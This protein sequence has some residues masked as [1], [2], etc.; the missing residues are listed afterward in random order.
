[1]RIFIAIFV[2]ILLTGC[3]SVMH[4]P[5]QYL[6]INSSPDQALVFIDGEPMGK[7]PFVI[8]LDAD[9]K[10][11]ITVKK[12]GY[13]E[14]TIEIDKELNPWF[15]GNFGT[16]IPLGMI[17]DLATG[18]MYRL[19]PSDINVKLIGLGSMNEG[20]FRVIATID[21]PNREADSILGRAW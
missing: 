19:T 9:K 5:D 8:S 6:N 2:A 16:V 11:T 7:T 17:V 1:M 3:A 4:G 14:K 18:S 21:T 15:W 13:V 10:H 20:E 12:D